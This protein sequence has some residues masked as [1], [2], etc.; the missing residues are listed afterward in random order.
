MT[1]SVGIDDIPFTSLHS[2]GF[3]LVPSNNALEFNANLN[4]PSSD[5]IQDKLA[6]LVSKVVGQNFKDVTER[7]L[8]SNIRFGT[9]ESDT[10]DILNKVALNV[11]ISILLN[12]K[13]LSLLVAIV[14]NSLDF[15]IRHIDPKSLIE[16]VTLQKLNFDAGHAEGFLLE[17]DAAMSKI[18]MVLDVDIG[19]YQGS[20]LLNDE[21]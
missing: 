20:A 5:S 4:F 13:V 17:A 18:P 16:R 14:Q 2:T 3:A 19:H 15:D 7:A 1:A 21:M 9:S 10:I 12:D 6:N 8:V 11:P